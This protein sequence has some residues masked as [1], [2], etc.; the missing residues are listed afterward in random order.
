[1]KALDRG[2]SQSSEIFFHIPSDFAVKALY[3]ISYVG[4]FEC[5]KN[6]QI[7][8][9]YLNLFLLIFIDDGN[10]TITYRKKTMIAIPG[11]IVILDCKEPH[12]YGAVGNLKFHFF[13]FNGSGSQP[14]FDLITSENSYILNPSRRL[15]VDSSFETI[16]QLAKENV[17]NEHLI[18]V[19]VH[20]ILSALA[21]SK[22]EYSTLENSIVN[23]S[24]V[25]IEKFFYN[26]LSVKD[27]ADNVN[28][29]EFYFS[30]LFKKYTNKSPHKYL[31][32]IRLNY[33]QK[34]LLTSTKTI[35]VIASE[36]GFK[37]TTQFIRAFKKAIGITPN[38]FRQSAI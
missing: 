5:T 27:I 1:M 21:L 20:Y 29:S 24:I 8:R 32:G 11:D 31:L 19:Q 36:C 9:N 33:S 30:R 15:M 37:S 12:S 26:D 14:Y 2:V 25:F 22:N 23:N 28:L 3:Y 18:S 6:Y 10:M 34:Q 38:K 4:N 17:L 13:H 16:F 35:E 7:T